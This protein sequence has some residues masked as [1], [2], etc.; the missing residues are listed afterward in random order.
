MDAS[1]VSPPAGTA[2]SFRLARREALKIWQ[3][4]SR[5]R[6]GL[7]TISR[8]PLVPHVRL[9]KGRGLVLAGEALI[10]CFGRAAG[11]DRPHG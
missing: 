4:I 9:R 8:F 10:C 7:S 2:F 3:S 11:I 1:P 5:R 6:L